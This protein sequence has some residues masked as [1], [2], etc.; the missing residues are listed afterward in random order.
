MNI[1]AIIQARTGSKRLPNKVLTELSGKPMLYHVVRRVEKSVVD[2][3]VVATTGN[4]NDNI[5][6]DLC[7]QY[8]FCC[9]RGD[10]DDVLDRVYKAS[11]EHNAD[12]IVRITGDC[13]FI[14]PDVINSVIMEFED[15]YPHVDYVSN[16]LPRTYPRGLDVELVRFSTLEEEW[17]NTTIWRE[18]VTLNIRKNNNKYKIFNISN[19]K[20][21]S[22]MRWCIDDA[23]DL[24]FAQKVYSYFNGK[25]FHMSDILKLLN[26]HPEWIIKDT[27]VDP[28]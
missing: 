4:K 16:L 22:Y 20:D 28:E 15:K 23:N 8:G 26:K 3:V 6:V 13:P 10:E 7:N 1:V 25:L 5:V 21:Y 12:A 14:E 11:I 17:I 18:H 24:E 19:D 2:K 9:F 27:Q